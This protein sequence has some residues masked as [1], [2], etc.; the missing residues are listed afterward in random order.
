MLVFE[1]NGWPA[2]FDFGGK[3]RDDYL[4]TQEHKKTDY[5]KNNRFFVIF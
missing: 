3:G 5:S 2:F 1:P 4:Y